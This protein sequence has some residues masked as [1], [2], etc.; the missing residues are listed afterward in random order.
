MARGRFITEFEKE[1]I[2]IGKAKNIDNATIARALNRTKASIGQQV[3]AMEN[4]GTLDDL[5]L[6]FVVDDIADMMRRTGGKK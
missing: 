2:R 1:C 6:A 5:P 4:A 3:K